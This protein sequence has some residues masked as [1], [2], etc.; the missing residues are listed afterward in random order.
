M[1]QVLFSL[2]IV[3]STLASGQSKWITYTPTNSDLPHNNINRVVNPKNGKL[4]IASTGGITEFDGVNWTTYNALDGI[5]SNWMFSVAVTPQNEIWGGMITSGATHYD[6][7]TWTNYNSSGTALPNNTVYDVLYSSSGVAW[8]STPLGIASNT[9]GTWA[10]FG[11]GTTSFFPSP[12]VY[13]LEEGPTGDIWLGAGPQGSW[14]GGI[15]K[16][17][18]GTN[19]CV[20]YR[21]FNGLVNNNVNDLTFDTLGNIWV[22][23]NGGISKFDGFNFTNYTTSN[24]DLADDWV[25]AVTID[26]AGIIWFGTNNGLS[27]FDGTTW[28]TFNSTNSDL[29]NNNVKTLTSD[30]LGNIWMGT[31]TGVTVYK[32]DAPVF[33]QATLY[34]SPEAC[35][36]EM[37]TVFVEIIGAT[38]PYTI[39][40]GTLAPPVTNYNS[41]DSITFTFSTSTTLELVSVS[42]ASNSPIDSLKG[43]SNII[44]N[45]LPNV[46][47]DDYSNVQ[48]CNSANSEPLPSATPMG[49][50]YTGIGISGNVFNPQI[51]GNGTFYTTYTYTDSK[52]CEN[53]DSTSIM[54]DVC[55]GITNKNNN[56]VLLYP[57]PTTSFLNCDNCDTFSSFEIFDINSLVVHSGT[58]S[59]KQLN[60]SHLENGLYLLKT[61]ISGQV[62]FRNFVVD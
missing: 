21:T 4:Y 15:S 33:S 32:P 45:E 46:I 22:A 41:G 47:I 23:T 38:G 26:T 5:A 58:W 44:I 7:N 60:I 3:S 14:Q 25:K 16:F 39:D 30:S 35:E 36:G 53:L 59:N 55:T 24:S 49:G 1:R 12:T 2:A 62:Y 52:G 9:N 34:G 8:F 50:I 28:T 61:S 51:S 27:R 43:N 31:T 56:S 29:P 57:N 13:A 48:V 18:P 54:V 10:S 37:T 6:G 42:D 19:T 20:T 17:T 11:T 40:F